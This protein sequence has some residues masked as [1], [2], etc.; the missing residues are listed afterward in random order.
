[1]KKIRSIVNILLQTLK[2]QTLYKVPKI[3]FIEI[4][5]IL[6]YLQKILVS[7]LSQELK[8][9]TLEPEIRSTTNKMT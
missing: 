1:M 6:F 3:K 4:F 8:V 5:S 9:F 2:L 7:L